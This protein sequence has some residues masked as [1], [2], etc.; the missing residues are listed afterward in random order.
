M[1]KEEYINDLFD[2]LADESLRP[3][4]S[5]PPG[6]KYQSDL[7]VSWEARKEAKQLDDPEYIPILKNKLE[8]EKK[9]E[10]RIDVIRILTHL[11]AKVED[12]SIADYLLNKLKKEKVRWIKD[13]IM[14]SLNNHRLQVQTE[15][16][17][18]FEL[19]EHKHWPIKQGALGILSRWDASFS[20]KIEELCLRQI[21]LNKKKPH[22][23][24]GLCQVL[25]NHGSEKSLESLKVIAETNSRAFTINTALIAIKEIGGKDELPFFI[26]FFKH[27]RNKD[28]KPRV[29]LILCSVGDETIVDL[30]IKR[31]EAILKK[32]RK[33]N[34]IYLGGTK[35][36]LVHIWIF[37][38]EYMD[39]RVY[40]L[41]E[42]IQRKK[43]DFLD[44]PEKEWFEA[45][46]SEKLKK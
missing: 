27:I 34:T 4:L 5:L 20:T 14:D 6:V 21:E 39:E 37:L 24:N 19:A 40:D 32:K 26:D 42:Y 25:C 46:V 17:F 30:V 38:L 1:N 43:M 22:E 44:V 28:V 12:H 36:E 16:E 10:R 3:G 33:T 13:V 2:R 9:T 31:V 35:P 45:N 15:K 41:F 29:S 18:I 23:L 11:A 7:T 8:K